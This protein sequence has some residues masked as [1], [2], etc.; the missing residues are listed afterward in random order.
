MKALSPATLFFVSCSVLSAIQLGAQNAPAIPNDEKSELVTSDVRAL[1]RIA[2][3]APNLN[4]TRPVMLA[5]VDSDI[6]MLRDR[7]PD[8]TYRWAALQREEAS[9]VTDEKTIERVHT[10]AELRHVTVTAANAYRVEVIVPPKRSLVS[11]NN[12]VFVRNVIVDATAFDGKTSHHEIPINVWVN[13]GDSTGGPLPAIGKSVKAMVELGVESG[14]KKAVATVALIQAKLVDDPTTPYYP[15]VKR[16]LQLREL[17][18]QKDL[19]RGALKSTLDEALLA[20]PG[21]IEKRTAAMA[22][23]E[24]RRRQQALSGTPTGGIAP[25]DA[26]P[27]VVLALQEIHRLLGGTLAD[28]EAARSKLQSLSESL[29]TKPAAQASTAARP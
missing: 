3:L 22:A 25:G 8:G 20:M 6:E 10:E 15:A 14:E 23:A 16:L 26:T 21:E 28:Q 29:Q 12:P 27:D 13:P 4:D 11:A 17:I 19:N 7:R 1:H 9:R 24:E 18:A 2:S 5:I